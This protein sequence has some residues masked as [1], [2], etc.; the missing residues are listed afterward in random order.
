M[1]FVQL[2]DDFRVESRVLFTE[3]SG[4][5]EECC[6]H[7]FPASK[8]VGEF[9]FV[10]DVAEVDFV[11]EASRFLGV[12]TDLRRLDNA[13]FHESNDHGGGVFAEL[14]FVLVKKAGFCFGDVD[15]VVRHRFLRGR[16]GVFS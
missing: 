5:V 16:L 14:F 13:L 3:F 12:F 7:V 4:P 6:F 9:A 10:F 15:F 8:E 11:D 1:V 2:G